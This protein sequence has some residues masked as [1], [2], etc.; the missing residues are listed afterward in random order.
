MQTNP[1]VLGPLGLGE[2][3]DRAFRLVRMNFG[4]LILIA[5]IFMVPYAIVSGILTGSAMTGYMD[6]IENMVNSPAI[7]PS[8]SPEEI[9]TTILGPLSNFFGLFLLIGLIGLVVQSAATLALTHHHLK[10][11]QHEG[12]SVSVSIIAGGRRLT[13]YIGMMIVEALVMLGLA[14]LVLLVFGCAIGALAIGIGGTS[15]LFDGAAAIDNN[16][17]GFAGFIILF[18]CLYLFA[19]LI[20]VAP[21][22]YF[23]CRWLV[24]APSLLNEE[25]GPIEALQ[26][27]WRLSKGQVWRTVGYGIL[28]YILGMIIVS[29]PA[30]VLQQIATIFLSM[31]NIGAAT[32]I[33]SGVS[34]LFGIL[35]QPFFV[36]ALVLFYYDLRI[37]K[38]G[39]DL[40]LRVQQMEVDA[41]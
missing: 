19:L 8:N 37:R 35:W 12:S 31:E 25:L 21:M 28:L 39:Y 29:A 5:A 23:W 3:L 36:A 7:D 32:G 20:M 6:F 11:L 41:Q 38:E 24:A 4:Q 1:P 34:A 27:S 10:T 30:Y 22:I 14:L 13:A 40:A 33:A 9:F 2:L 17:A 16:V 18:V 26:R 15:G